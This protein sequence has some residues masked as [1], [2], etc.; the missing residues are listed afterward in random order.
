MA[1]EKKKSTFFA[2]FKKFLTEGNALSMAIGVI[3][4]T[5]L[6]DVVTSLVEN[7]F[8]PIIGIFTGHIDF[9]K[10]AVDLGDELT[11]RYGAFIT[12]LINFVIL[13]FVVF[14]VVR[15]INKFNDKLKELSHKNS[16]E[17]VE[18]PTT[19]ICPYCQ[20]EISIKAVRCPHC[21]SSLDEE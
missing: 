16:E 5:A 14:V 8:N 11:I 13:A 12:A 4:G 3:I 18:E 6:K 17:Q 1:K 7:I 20:S 2:D 9:S 10:L 21:T 15:F 19:K